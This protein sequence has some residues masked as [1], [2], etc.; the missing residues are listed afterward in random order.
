MLT[1]LK[2]VSKHTLIYG[3]GIVMGKAIGFF[4]I[5]LYT[6]YLSPEEYGLL[7]LVD[8]TGF[9]IGY[10][11]VVGI[12]EAILKYYNEAEKQ[13]EKEEYISTS[14][15]FVILLGFVSLAILLPFKDSFAHYVLGSAEHSN[16][17]AILFLSMCLGSSVGLTKSIIRAQQ[18]SMFFVG[19]TL[20]AIFLQVTLNIY[21]VAYLQI[22]VKG[23]LYSSLIVSVLFG[24]AL[25]VYML[26]ITGVGF[27]AEKLKKMLKYGMPLVPAGIMAFVLNWSDRYFLRIFVDME[28]I[29]IYSLGYKLGMISTFFV[30]LPF[31]FIWGSYIFDVKKKQNA[32]DIYAKFA[33]YFLLILSFSGLAL[34]SLSYELVTLIAD[35]SYINAYKVIPVIVLSMMFMNANTVFKVGLLIEGRTIQLTIANSIAAVINIPLNILLIPE[36]GMMGAAYA[37]ALSFLVYIAYVLYAAQKCYYINFEYLRIIKIGFTGIMIY[38]MSLL[39]DLESTLYSILLKTAIVALF[40]LILYVIN[41]Y[42]KEELNFCFGK[43]KSVLDRKAR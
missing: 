4:M 40:P 35:D 42:H 29:G 27:D 5:P 11:L 23:I 18:K 16:L 39:V 14:L 28:E 9:I 17:F 13:K 15:I 3:F 24:V 32:K 43:I 25:S 12:D 36:F 2:T 31:S 33:T 38:S 7:E 20:F 8:V 41:F 6:H 26:R 37:T 21:F 22:G 34:S 30:T 1:E 19:V 10:F